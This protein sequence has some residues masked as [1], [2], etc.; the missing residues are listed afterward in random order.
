MSDLKLELSIKE[1]NALLFKRCV[2]KLLDSTF[3]VG[4]KDRALYSYIAR[5]SNRQDIADYFRMIDFDVFVDTTVRIAMLK[6]H[7]SDEGSVRLKQSNVVSFSKEQYH[8]LLVFWQF[9]LEKVGFSEQVMVKRKDLI[10]RLKAYGLDAER[11]DLNPA[12]V[13]F[14]KYNLINYDKNDKTEDALIILYPSLQFGWNLEQFR[15]RADEFMKA[16]ETD[17]VDD[18]DDLE[19][20]E[21]DTF[22]DEE[23]MHDGEV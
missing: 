6:P 5:E 18:E 3:I 15:I 2:R 10:D 14:R 19:N 17:S 12:M 11:K 22:D 7:E 21:S 1:E 4:D 9:Y 23:Y 16:N 20:S 13:L 8:M